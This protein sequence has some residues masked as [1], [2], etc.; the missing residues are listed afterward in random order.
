MNEEIKVH[1]VNYG[2]K[3]LYM[4]YR[5]PT[6]GKHVTRSTGTRRKRDAERIAAKWEADLQ[7]GRYKAPSKT[8]WIDFRERYDSEVLSGL[9]DKTAPKV[10]GLFNTIERILNPRKLSELTAGRIRHY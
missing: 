1:V 9:A 10:W 5:D 2:R 8:T 3:S 7:E 4:R 6:I